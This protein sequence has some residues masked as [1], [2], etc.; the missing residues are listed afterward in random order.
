M[1]TQ[2]RDNYSRQFENVCEEQ[3]MDQPL[4]RHWEQEE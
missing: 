3:T 4:Y 1:E 2:L